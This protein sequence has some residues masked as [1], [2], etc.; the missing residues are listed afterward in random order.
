MKTEARSTPSNIVS[1]PPTRASEESSPAQEVR[2]PAESSCFASANAEVGKRA[3]NVTNL[4]ASHKTGITDPSSRDQPV[5]RAGEPAN[6]AVTAPLRRPTSSAFAR[7]MNSA[8]GGPVSWQ[9]RSQLPQAFWIPRHSFDWS[10]LK[11]FSG[12][13]GVNRT[14]LHAFR[15]L[16]DRDGRSHVRSRSHSIPSKV[17]VTMSTKASV[18]GYNV[19]FALVSSWVIACSTDRGSLSP[20]A[21]PQVTQFV[22]GAALQALDAQGHFAMPSPGADTLGPA[23][24]TV[25][26]NMLLKDYGQMAIGRYRRETGLQFELEET[27]P[28]G[29]AF[30]ATSPYDLVQGG[31]VREQ[32]RFGP[33]WLVTFCLKGNTPVIS[34]S[35]SALARELVGKDPRRSTVDF[36]QADFLEA[37]IRPGVLGLP[38]SPE[39]AV[40]KIAESSGRKISELPTLLQL[41]IPYIPQLAAWQVTLDQAVR[42]RGERSTLESSE[43]QLYYAWDDPSRSMRLQRVIAP[44]HLM[45]DSTLG[46]RGDPAATVRG[47]RKSGGSSALEPVLVLVPGSVP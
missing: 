2:A 19:V 9:R 23:E 39:V 24:A 46:F 3:G 45:I 14:D 15:E 43:R 22:T 34:V 27:A 21:P 33:H 25:L 4:H 10:F 13:V 30:L 36:Q 44:D 7:G 18:S 32:R 35:V 1:G 28:C 20:S 5:L 26:A 16:R 12:P 6:P 38:V 8:I 41:P 31:S 11:F 29:R 40:Q 17:R 37:S 42:V 47:R